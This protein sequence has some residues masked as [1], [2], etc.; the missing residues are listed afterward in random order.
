MKIIV[1]CQA[2]EGSLNKRED[3]TYK[4]GFTVSGKGVTL[5]ALVTLV[6]TRAGEKPI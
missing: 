3:Y 2:I 4:S 1:G 5:V 6:M